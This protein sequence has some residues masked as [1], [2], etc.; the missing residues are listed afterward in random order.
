MWRGLLA[1]AVSMVAAYGFLVALVY[2]TQVIHV[3]HPVGHIAHTPAD[4][5]LEYE[6]VTLHTADGLSLGAWFV[7]AED[8]RGAVLFLQGN[9]GNRSHRVADLAVFNKLGYATLIVDYRSFGDSEGRPTEEGT[10]EDARSAWRY[11]TE[12]RGIPAERIVIF[13][14]SL[15]ASVGAWLAA[16][17]RPGAVILAAPFTSAADVG[18]EAFPWLPVRRLLKYDYDTLAAAPRIQAPTLILHGRSDREVPLAHGEA[19]FKALT[20]PREM[21]VLEGGHN[22]SF[23]LRNTPYLDAVDGF[24]TTHFE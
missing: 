22:E 9:A 4:E 3:Y 8:A 10:Y 14:R 24:L 18:A 16:R 6:D 19:V 12:E 7:P 21:V 15:G 2:F 5:A 13:G 20:A 23:D 11:L 17:E 1:A